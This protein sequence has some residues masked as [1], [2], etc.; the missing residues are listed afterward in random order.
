MN[1]FEMVYRSGNR[2]DCLEH[3]LVLK[4][5]GI[6]HRT[7]ARGGEFTI[8]VASQDA[9]QSLS[10]FASYAREN[11]EFI[12]RPITLALHSHS[13]YGVYCYITV[14]LMVAICDRQNLFDF[15]WVEAGRTHANQIQTG[16]WWR[17]I[18]ALTLHSDLAHM[19][20]NLVIGSLFGYFAGQMLGVGLAWLSIL[21]AGAMGNFVNA[22]IRHA[23][24][25]SIGA[26][27]A[28]FAALGIVAA[29][30]WTQRK[31]VHISKLKRWT[32]FVGGAL[33]LSFLGTGGGR[34][35][36][37][38]H[39]TGFFSGVLLGILYAKFGEG[40]VLNTRRQF[41]L[42]VTTIMVLALA[43]VI[44]LSN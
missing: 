30:S 25:T 20:A 26:S 9:T 11:R 17:T 37:V 32:P 42:G 5:V 10:E 22:W 23:T 33:L 18:T 19:L 40:V 16:E 35:D 24:H 3:T 14:M 6:R 38:A 13:F 36:V 39:V 12:S 34:T 29:Y 31:H 2:K 1:P 15:D 4:S 41:W 44:A 27:T 21:L 8:F 28:V 7:E 43:W